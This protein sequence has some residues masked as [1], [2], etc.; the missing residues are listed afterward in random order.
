M[1]IDIEIRDRAKIIFK[2]R[3]M[4]FRIGMDAINTLSK[5]YGVGDNYQHEFDREL[6]EIER[7]FETLISRRKRSSRRSSKKK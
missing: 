4:P 7:D 6:K 3:Q 1:N 2:A 5:K